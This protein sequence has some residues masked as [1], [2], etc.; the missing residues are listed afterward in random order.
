MI[1]CI[2]PTHRGGYLVTE[3]LTELNESRYKDLE[4]II[5]EDGPVKEYR[6][7]ESLNVKV[8]KLEE[9]SGSVSIPRAVG[10]SYAKGEFISHV[11]DDVMQLPNKFE[12]LVSSIG[13]NYLCYGNRMNLILPG[14]PNHTGSNTD[15][16]Y[17]NIRPITNWN[18][19]QPEGWG[20][21]NGQYIYRADVWKKNK[22]IFP[23]RGCDW[24][25][26]KLI[27]RTNNK[28]KYVD[29]IVCIY[30]WHKDNRSNNDATKTKEIYPEKYTKYFNPEFINI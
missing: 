27:A 26:A 19:L 17:E 12:V 16:Y 8:I 13:D 10:L 23:K 29:S 24:E 22:F 4:V 18:P 15:I 3:R 1:S 5:V 7:P 20:V 11:D 6:V 30:I 25:T 28:F 9:N 14:A 2:L 21:D